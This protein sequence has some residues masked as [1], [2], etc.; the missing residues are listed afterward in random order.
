MC[1]VCVTRLISCCFCQVSCCLIKGH[2][3]DIAGRKLC[4]EVPVWCCA[5]C[6]ALASVP[7]RHLFIWGKGKRRSN[8]PSFPNTVTVESCPQWEVQSPVCLFWVLWLT[9]C[10]WVW[11]KYTPV[12]VHD[13]TPLHK[14]FEGMCFFFQTSQ[15][16]VASASAPWVTEPSL[17]RWLMMSYL[18]NHHRDSRKENKSYSMK[19]EE[20]TEIEG[21][22]CDVFLGVL[23]WECAVQFLVGSFFFW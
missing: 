9:S 8:P 6:L 4:Q 12:T 18:G 21:D 13:S 1:G 3:P 19:R 2:S 16:K 10:W 20:K 11:H 7:K 22:G 17:R 5:A 23:S 15:T 14:I